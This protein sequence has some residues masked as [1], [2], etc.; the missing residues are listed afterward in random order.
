MVNLFEV[1]A[2]DIGMLD[3]LLVAVNTWVI[4]TG[5]KVHLMTNFIFDFVKI[6]IIIVHWI[7]LNEYVSF[8]QRKHLAWN[9][10]ILNNYY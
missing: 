6:L 5:S 3:A 7:S 4:W 2:A 10:H 1:G 8:L 9:N